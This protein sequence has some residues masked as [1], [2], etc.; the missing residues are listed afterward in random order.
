MS[1]GSRLFRWIRSAARTVFL[2]LRLWYRDRCPQKAEAL[3]FT[4]ALSL[5]PLLAVL[6]TGLKLTGAL[7]A[8]S[9]LVDFLARQ[10]LPDDA[11]GDIVKGL[12]EFSGH[13]DIKSVGLSGLAVTLLVAFLLFHG[14]E[15]MFDDV[16]R[17]DRQRGLTPKFLVFYLLVT[18]VPPALGWSLYPATVIAERSS[19]LAYLLPAF[20]SFAALYLA[21][22]LLPNTRVLV[23]PALLASLVG[24]PF[25][26]AAKAGFQFYVARVAF[27]SYAFGPRE[28]PQG[29]GS[30]PR[31]EERLA[32]LA[33]AVQRTSGE[34]TLAQLLQGRP[35][36]RY[37]FDSAPV[38]SPRGASMRIVRMPR[39]FEQPNRSSA[40]VSGRTSAR[41]A[42]V[43]LPYPE[44][45]FHPRIDLHRLVPLRNGLFE[46]HPP[47]HP[48]PL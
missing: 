42:G 16:W 17:I 40:P 29:D 21:N 7:Q 44:L 47:V 22:E 26:E 10:I 27:S 30:H 25:L 33:D 12:L 39:Q 11:R 43:P 24:A 37:G 5:V 32:S 14:V 48:G 35:G 23:W 36:R 31:L 18:L 20:G 15:R 8:Q 3:A 34:V 41:R 45:P 1:E 9:A 2:V 13:I 4:T 19:L 38:H 6:V 46:L 28:A